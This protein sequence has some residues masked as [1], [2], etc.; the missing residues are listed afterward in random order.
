MLTDCRFDVD[1]LALDS[2]PETQYSCCFP[3]APR[4]IVPT[5][6]CPAPLMA[7]STHGAGITRSTTAALLNL[8]HLNCTRRTPAGFQCTEDPRRKLQWQ[9]VVVI[10]VL[11]SLFSNHP[12]PGIWDDCTDGSHPP[13]TVGPAAYYARTVRGYERKKDDGGRQDGSYH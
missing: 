2:H 9:R 12:H 3:V 13:L 7:T 6:H 5:R 8:Y 11:R 1:D 4:R 10:H